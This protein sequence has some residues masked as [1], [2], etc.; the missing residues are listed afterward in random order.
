MTRSCLSA[1]A[2]RAAPVGGSS[3]LSRQFGLTTLV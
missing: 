3:P 2:F 1:G